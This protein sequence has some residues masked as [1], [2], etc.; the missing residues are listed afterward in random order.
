MIPAFDES[1]YLPPGVHR[2]TMD[3]IVQRFGR[4][5]ELR[6]AQ[7]ESIGWM[8]EIALRAGVQRI[9]LNGSFVS[10]IIEPNDVD[11]VLLF[12]PGV[13]KSGRAFKELRIGLP[14]LD[15]KLV[16]SEDFDV[17]VN[18]FFGADRFGNPKGMIEVIL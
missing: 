14:F 1:G 6:R 16:G 17:Y 8:F 7:M 12:A 13:R 4:E 9:V 3:E 5:S 10:D 15:I 18:E 11:C 2:A